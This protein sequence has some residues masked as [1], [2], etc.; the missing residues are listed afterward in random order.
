[1]PH[2]KEEV[3]KRQGTTSEVQSGYILYP[4]MVLR[5]S[6]LFNTKEFDS[7]EEKRIKLGRI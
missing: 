6:T 2:Q 5:L 3:S 4:S 1:L 7:V